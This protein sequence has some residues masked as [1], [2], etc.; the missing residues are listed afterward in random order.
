MKTLND[1]IQ[2]ARNIHCRTS[3]KI[4]VLS[5]LSA[6]LSRGNRTSA[7]RAAI[8]FNRRSRA[9]SL[10]PST[11]LTSVLLR[12]TERGKKGAFNLVALTRRIL[13]A[14]FAARTGELP[15]VLE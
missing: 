7:S 5:L 14:T 10:T 9:V 2:D 3:R 13:S 6:R 15:E 4:I 1:E 11:A 8:L 12:E